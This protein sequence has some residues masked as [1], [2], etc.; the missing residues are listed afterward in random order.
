MW[1]KRKKKVCGVIQLI[2]YYDK[3]I[4]KTYATDDATYGFSA[5]SFTKNEIGDDIKEIAQQLMACE[6]YDTNPN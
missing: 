4:I 6:E 2:Q 3:D 1:F 5:A